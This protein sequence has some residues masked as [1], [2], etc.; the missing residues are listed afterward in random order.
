MVQTDTIHALSTVEGRAGIAVIR[1]SGPDADVILGHLTSVP[2][3]RPREMALRTIK[4]QTGAQLDRGLVV[5]FPEGGSF[6]GEPVVELHLHGSIAVVRAVLRRLEETGLTRLAEPGEFT[7]RALYNERLD[8]TQV[9]GLSDLIDAETELQRRSAMRVFEGDL[10]H[11]VVDW[12]RDLIEAA[13]YLEATIDFADE[14]VPEDVSGPV[15]ERLH[16]VLS[17]MST[18]LAGV[19]AARAIRT[20]YTVAI[21][22]R[23]NAG[24]SSLINAI[25]RREVALVSEIPGTTRDVLE[26]RVDLGGYP[27]TF[28]DTA[29]LRSS[30]DRIERMGVERAIARSSEASMRLA[31]IDGSR[32]AVDAG[33]IDADLFV[34]TKTDIVGGWG[35]SSENGDGVADVLGFIQEYLISS[36]GM[37]GLVSELRDEKNIVAAQYHIQP[38]LDDVD[39]LPEVGAEQI[40]MAIGRLAEIIGE[41]DIDD[42]LDHIFRSF[43]LGK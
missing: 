11:L 8:I 41:V 14:E 39:I 1:L 2:L 7:R 32:D 3:P 37:A 36:I 13:S 27:V 25:A 9:Q 28:L 10:R 17:S 42:I 26:I 21:V 34:R 35:I 29:G 43:C 31:L 24:K 19:Q 4:D 16:R 12:R 38:V 33:G 30:G 23:P 40:R 18:Q 6:T 15:A 22:G 5:R 20:G